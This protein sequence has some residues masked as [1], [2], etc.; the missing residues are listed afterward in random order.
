MVRLGC[1]EQIEFSLTALE[2][3]AAVQLLRLLGYLPLA[4][5]QAGAFMAVQRMQR[6]IRD[7]LDIYQCQPGE[8]LDDWDS[9]VVSNYPK[10]TLLTT[11][12]ISYTAVQ[13]QMPEAAKLLHL[14]SFLH[15][16]GIDEDILHHGEGVSP[17]KGNVFSTK[18]FK[19][20]LLK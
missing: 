15:F 7:Y 13:K 17:S 4:I 9:K 10:G 16:S 20:S 12:G 6:P 14:L 18:S 2:W 1:Q 3:E 19:S 8:F 5:N 11:W